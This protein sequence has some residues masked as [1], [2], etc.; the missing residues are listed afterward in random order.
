MRSTGKLTTVKQRVEYLEGLFLTGDEGSALQE[1][2]DDYRQQKKHLRH[3]FKA[4]HLEVGARMYAMSG[5]PDRARGIMDE[6]FELYPDWDSSIMMV[7]FRAYTQSTTEQH[8]EIARELYTAMKSRLGKYATL[9]DYDSWFLGFL[10]TRN[11]SYS[12]R[13][14]KAMVTDG[15]IARDTTE[16]EIAGVLRRLHLLYRLGDGIGG[17]TSIAL[18]SITVLPEFY[19]PHLF[20]DWVKSAAVNNSPEAAAQIL[21]MMVKRGYEPQTFHS[22]LLLKALFRS[23]ELPNELKAEN[24]AWQMIAAYQSLYEPRRSLSAVDAI[25]KRRK[26]TTGMPPDPELAGKMPPANVTTFAL[27]M[28]WHANRGQWEHVEYLARWLRNSKIIP[29]TALLNVTMENLCRQGKYNEVWDQYRSSA[30]ISTDSVEGLHGI[31]PDGATFRC[32]WRTLRL[33]LSDNGMRENSSL[34]SPRELLRETLQWWELVRDRPDAPRFRIGLA[35]PNHGALNTLMMH[36]FSYCNDLGG[37]L[38]ALHLCWKK[39]GLLPSARAP[40][41]LQYQIAWVDARSSVTSGRDHQSGVVKRDVDKMAQIYDILRRERFER[42]GMTETKFEYLSDAEVADMN[43]N[44]ISEFVRVILKRKHPPED[45]EA[46]ID[47]AKLDLG[48]PDMKIGD[49]DAYNVA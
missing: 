19:R 12:T 46:M 11:L 10:E 36:S 38:V 1:W 39:L 15:F 8:H 42:A 29:N 21:E 48:C 20:G 49:L 22:N 27:L 30:N 23:K 28:R 18:A 6:L 17:M 3:D 34:P 26:D 4:E 43:L 25:S 35:A 14:F 31:F 13:V 9:R 45:I 41:I 33:A 2:E 16:G 47:E 32:L 24:M 7:V 40:R 5:N 44:L 37:S